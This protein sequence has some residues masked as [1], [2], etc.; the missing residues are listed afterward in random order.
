MRSF[1]STTLKI[2][3]ALAVG[4]TIAIASGRTRAAD[5]LSTWDIDSGHSAVE[6]GV[7]HL[8]V[9]TVK[10][11]FGK[12]SGELVLDETDPRKS[13]VTAKIDPATID[14]REPKRDAHLKSPDFFDVAKYPTVTFKSTKIKNA[15][16]GEL[17]VTGDLTI[18]DVTK[19]V[20]LAVEGPTPAVKD[21]KGGLVR[22]VSLSGKI[23]R[24]DWGL[25]WNKPLEAAGGVLVG[26]EV[27][28]DIQIEL[29]QRREA[30]PG[31]APGATAKEP[32]ARHGL[33]AATAKQ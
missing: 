16:R 5:N 22:G 11:Q 27:S 3:V 30:P 15:G 9:S 17:E 4:S 18:R 1:F 12:V 6:F 32:A 19:P 24:K 14:T 28:L 26:D 33:A 7:R 8:T 2:S 23:N 20:T 10:G 25:T 21:L 29:H 13:T 31:T